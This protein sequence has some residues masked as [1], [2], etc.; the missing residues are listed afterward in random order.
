MT[1][2]R[3]A[4]PPD[5]E[6]RLVQRTVDVGVRVSDVAFGAG[7]LWAMCAAALGGGW[8]AIERT[9]AAANGRHKPSQKTLSAAVTPS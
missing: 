1:I 9:V 7:G 6:P 5:P 2:V 8:G 4:L 3:N